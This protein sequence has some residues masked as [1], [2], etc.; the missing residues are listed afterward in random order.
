MRV[1][2]PDQEDALEVD[3]ETS[4]S[5]LIW[6]IP[7]TEEPGRLQSMGSQRGRY[8]W[9]DLACVHTY[10]YAYIQLKNVDEETIGRETMQHWNRFQQRFFRAFQ[11]APGNFSVKLVCGPGWAG[12]GRGQVW[13]L[14]RVTCRLWAVVLGHS[15]WGW[16]A[17]RCLPRRL[18]TGLGL[19]SDSP[20]QTRT[21]G[22]H[23]QSELT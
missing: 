19:R 14:T 8:D 1:W 20:Q 11:L 13:E 9:S 17:F 15:S 5:I 2:Y 10:M 6:R 16:T 4:S 22:S 3:M 23:R 18:L 7:W 21:L 12:A